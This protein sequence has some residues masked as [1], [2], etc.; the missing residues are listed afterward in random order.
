MRRDIIRS[1]NVYYVDPSQN[2]NSANRKSAEDFGVF[3]SLGTKNLLHT[4]GVLGFLAL[5]VVVMVW[6]IVWIIPN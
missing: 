2:G 6:T 1:G 4:L 3:Y 5:A